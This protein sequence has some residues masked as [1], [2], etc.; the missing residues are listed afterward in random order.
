MGRCGLTRIFH[1]LVVAVCCG[2]ASSAWGD[3]GG[4][5]DD[6]SKWICEGTDTPVTPEQIGAWC[7]DHPDRGEP[8]RFA[9]KPATLSDLA[10]K[11]AYDQEFRSFLRARTY[12]ALGWHHDKRWRLTGPYVGDL[13]TGSSYG[14][15]PLVRIYY[16][17]EMVD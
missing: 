10:A 6:P 8:A 1:A 12:R 14:V 9:T 7:R 2:F 5:P 13:G 17:P 4:L 15:H 3:T 16:S 11:N